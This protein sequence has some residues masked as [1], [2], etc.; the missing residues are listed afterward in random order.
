MVKAVCILVFICA[1]LTGCSA[2]K[3]IS[4]ITDIDRDLTAAKLAVPDNTQANEY[5]VLLFGN[6]HIDWIPQV[7][8]ILVNKSGTT[9]QLVA[10]GSNRAMFLDER[11]R[12]TRSIKL[13]KQ[14]AWTH[15]VLQG[16]KYSQSGR[17]KYATTA[18]EKWIARVK[19]HQATPILFPEHPQRG[20]LSEGGRVHR[21]HTAISD[22]VPSCVAPIGL[23]WDKALQSQS[24]LVLHAP[25]G[26]H[27]DRAGIV[28][29]A[30]VFY[31]VITGEPAESLPYIEELGLDEETQH[32]LGV[33]GAEEYPAFMR[34]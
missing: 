30:L 4:S 25:D 34:G 16:Q 11:L 26:N 15:V 13:L 27:A 17:K 5:K 20:N 32:L 14:N 28:L 23:A 9:K 7:L 19:S 31:Q 29:S 6:S 8:E 2:S 1:V 18:T 22:N 3:E 21:I 33:C 12:D 24:E 10:V